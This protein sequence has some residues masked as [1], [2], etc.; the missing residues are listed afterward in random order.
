MV[1]VPRTS[2]R[3]RVIL[4]AV[5]AVAQ[6]VAAPITSLTFGPN[7]NIGAISAANASPVTPAGY[8]FAIWS[9]IYSGCLALAVYQLLPGQHDRRVH[10]RSGWWLVGGFTAAAVWVPIFGLRISW[11]AQLLIVMLVI[12][13]VFAARGFLV[14]GPARSVAEIAL[15]RLP[16]M[17]YLG[18]ATLA[19]A[20]GFATTFR[21]WG[22]PA[23]ARWLDEICVVLVLS[24]TIMSLFVVGRLVAIA[25]FVLAA[26][27]ALLAIAL[28][29]DNDSVRLATVL[30]IVVVLC[31]VLGRTLRS[32]ERRVLL[33][34]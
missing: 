8:A 2:D 23:S 13:L 24:A 4:V 7:S 16:V 3:V 33:L 19:A 6:A 1:A 11:L 15:L 10:R 30:A 34:G 29:T 25:G 18:W 26:C 5:T 31:A 9:L 27:W 17:L 21:A 22:A 12:C 20:A 32:P 28:N 14:A